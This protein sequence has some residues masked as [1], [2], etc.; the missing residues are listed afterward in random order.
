MAIFG[1][2]NHE[3]QL[4]SAVWRRFTYHLAFPFPNFIIRKQIIDS[5]LNRVE[6]ASIGIDMRLRTDMK[7]EYDLLYSAYTKKKEKLGRE[8]TDPE[9]YAIFEDLKASDNTGILYMTLGYT[10]ADLKRAMRVALFKAMQKS[11]LTFEDYVR[12]LEMVGGTETHVIESKKLASL[13]NLNVSDN[14]SE[15]DDGKFSSPKTKHQ[16]D[17]LEEIDLDF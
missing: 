8:L 4:D 5:F 15:H 17:I 2:T 7:K 13:G 14:S 16:D 6:Q 9:Y 11:I 1:A 10:G 3:H 12:S